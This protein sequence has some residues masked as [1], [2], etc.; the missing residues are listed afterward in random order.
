MT[1]FLSVQVLERTDLSPFLLYSSISWCADEEKILSLPGCALWRNGNKSDGV[2]LK[3][4][5]WH[6]TDPLSCLFLQ[7]VS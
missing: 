1:R 4:C 7:C 2:G 3:M 6:C 5:W